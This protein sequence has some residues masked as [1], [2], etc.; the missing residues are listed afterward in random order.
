MVT[1]ISPGGKTTKPL[2]QQRKE[3][4][5]ILLHVVSLFTFRP[6]NTVTHLWLQDHCGGT[7]ALVW[8]ITILGDLNMEKIKQAMLKLSKNYHRGDPHNCSAVRAGKR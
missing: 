5:E 2:D 1:G 4:T 3:S 6:C 8:L 7:V